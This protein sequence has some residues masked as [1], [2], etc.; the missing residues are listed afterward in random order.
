LQVGWKNKIK[1]KQESQAV[2]CT[3]E[4]K[5]GHGFEARLS[6]TGILMKK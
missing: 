5:K 2:S 1:V 3:Q 6:Y 4:A